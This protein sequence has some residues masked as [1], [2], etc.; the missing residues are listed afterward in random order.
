[1]NFSFHATIRFFIGQWSYFFAEIKRTKQIMDELEERPALFVDEILRGTN[2]DH[3]T[4][5]VVKK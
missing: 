2:S 4:I 3:G 1:M 5:E